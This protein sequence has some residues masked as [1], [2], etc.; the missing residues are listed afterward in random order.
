MRVTVCC[1]GSQPGRVRLPL[2][3]VK[4]FKRRGL[5]AMRER[6]I[7]ISTSAGIIL[8]SLI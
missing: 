6:S 1:N 2:G 8:F 4:G 7:L 3:Y 5:D